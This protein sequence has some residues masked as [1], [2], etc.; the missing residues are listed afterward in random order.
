MALASLFAMPILVINM[1]G[2]MVI[3]EL[4]FQSFAVSLHSYISWNKD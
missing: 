2:E 3:L 1:G 4:L